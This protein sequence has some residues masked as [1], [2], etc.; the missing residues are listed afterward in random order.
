VWP[1]TLITVFTVSP[2]AVIGC[3]FSM[4]KAWSF[5][6][7]FA[8]LIADGYLTK[9]CLMFKCKE[10]NPTY[11]ILKRKM[12][13]SYV[14]GLSRFAGLM[15][16]ISVLIFFNE[17]VLLI[18]A[19]AFFVGVVANSITLAKVVSDSIRHSDKYQPKCS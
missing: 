11:N 2:F 3:G 13:E 14:F 10:V 18:F 17:T 19:S 12:R 1:A 6:I 15:I 9:I 16:L 7:G 8:S 5:A 4:V